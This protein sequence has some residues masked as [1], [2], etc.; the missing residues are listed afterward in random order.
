MFV[1]EFCAPV[2]L[3]SGCGSN[4]L[5]TQPDGGG[6][7]DASRAETTALDDAAAPADATAPM[8]APYDAA[9]HADPASTLKP[10]GASCIVAAECASGDCVDAICC[11]DASCGACESCGVPGTLGTCAPVPRLASDVDSNCSG[12]QACDGA[13]HCLAITGQLCGAASEC[14]SGFCADGVCCATGC[15]DQCYSCNQTAGMCMPVGGVEDNNASAT[16]SGAKTC[17]VSSVGVPGCKLK[18]GQTC[19]AD[20]EC[21]LGHCR[22]YYRDADGDGYGSATVTLTRC[23]LLTGP[24]AGYINLAGDCCD[25]DAQA[26][27][28]QTIPRMS[29]DACGSY[30]WNCKNGI[31]AQHGLCPDQGTLGA[32]SVGCGSPCVWTTGTLWT[33]FCI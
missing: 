25:G 24:P 6:H 23:D 22:T 1:L 8:D 3:F 32:Y 11:G 27:P 33:Q 13:G 4:S 2:C 10:N 28:A 21:A 9:T 26:N 29:A 7:D 31:E 17:V 15:T 19:G 16:C 30:D 14:L 5:P 12:T 18:D 20:D